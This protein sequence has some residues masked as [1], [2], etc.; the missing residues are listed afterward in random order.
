[1]NLKSRTKKAQNKTKQI[2]WGGGMVSIFTLE[3]KV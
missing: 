3:Q 1:M 2:D